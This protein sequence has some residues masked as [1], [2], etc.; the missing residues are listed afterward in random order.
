MAYVLLSY[1]DTEP[2]RNVLSLLHTAY[3]RVHILYYPTEGA[4]SKQ[5]RQT[6]ARF[7]RTRFGVE[8]HFERVRGNSI[9]AF[10]K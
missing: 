2:I 1:Y 5:D 6:L 3:D 8:P 4:P 7:I 10:T 9:E